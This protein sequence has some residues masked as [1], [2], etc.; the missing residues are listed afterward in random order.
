MT[1]S[2]PQT[3]AVIASVTVHHVPFIASRYPGTYARDFFRAH[4]AR[5]GQ[6]DKDVTRADA[7]PMIRQWAKETG[8]PVRDVFLTLADAYLTRNNITVT[9]A[10]KKE[11]LAAY[12]TQFP[13][14]FSS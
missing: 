1:S 3:D 4:A 7:G 6:A 2:T 5:F 13:A 12:E 11:A 14:A 10:A 8:E 9:D